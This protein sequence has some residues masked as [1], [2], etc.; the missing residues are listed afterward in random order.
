MF[1][2]PSGRKLSFI[3]IG[4]YW[5]REIKPSASSQELRITLS[6]A[7]WRGELAAANG[8]NRVD[9]LRALYSTCADFLAFIIPN[10]TEPPQTKE[11]D[12]GRVEV[13]RLIR[14][15]LPSSDPNTW[16]E[17]NCAE[18]FEAIG[19]VWDEE[20]LHLTAPIVMGVLLTQGE[21]YQWINEIKYR[22]PTFW[23]NARQRPTD[24]TVRRERTKPVQYQIQK[25]VEALAK[26]YGG[27]F[28]PD[29]MPVSER[30]RLIT[31]WLEGDD[32]PVKP[33][34]RTLRDYFRE[35][36]Y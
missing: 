17:A 5:S 19:D 25:A 27:K 4:K 33:S 36:Q 10:E 30:D 20:L 18:A 24:N 6:K 1:P 22:R 8:P 34:E 2:I 29:G 16:T 21:F 32:D 35:H 28:P 9:L 13:F 7:W 15:P 26:Q 31:K 11:L 23:G 12:D 3:E 14:V